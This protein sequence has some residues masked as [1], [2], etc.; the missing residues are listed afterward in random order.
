MITL[1]DTDVVRLLRKKSISISD[2]LQENVVAKLREKGCKAC[3]RRKLYG[4]L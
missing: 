3:N 4:G 1:T 2:T